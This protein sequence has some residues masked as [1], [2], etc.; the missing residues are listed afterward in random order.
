MADQHPIPD[1][2]PPPDPPPL[3]PIEKRG[4]KVPEPPPPPDDR[5]PPNEE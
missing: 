1:P 5:N 4:F 3:G 2:P